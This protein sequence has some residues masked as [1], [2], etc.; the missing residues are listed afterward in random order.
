MAGYEDK[1]ISSHC[2]QH[3]A[4]THL[5]HVGYGVEDEEWLKEDEHMR[6]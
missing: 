1:L 4:S 5:T 6:V 3:T 2:G